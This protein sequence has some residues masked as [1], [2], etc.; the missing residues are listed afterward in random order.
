MLPK[1]HWGDMAWEDFASGDTARWIA[2]LPVA[3]IEQHG[4][5]LPVATDTLIAEA[6]LDRVAA[7]IPDDLPATLLPVQA[8]G[9]S[10]EHLAFPGTL[11][12]SP[13]TAIRAWTEIGESV[14]RAGVRKLVIVTS[15]GGNVQAI[16][17]VARELRASLG[18]LVVTTHW[19]RFGYPDGLFT[20][21]EQHHGIHAGDIETSL[22]LAHRPD[23]VQMDKAENAEPVSVAM[24]REFR[25]LHPYTPAPFGWMTQD[26]HESGA[27]GDPRP[28]SA[29]KG[30]AALD[31][32][33]RG[34]VAL[35]QEI[36]RFDLS[37]LKDGPLG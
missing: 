35:L 30:E 33:A 14:F 5:H 22:V 10:S 15:H 8:I 3:A 20:P 13:E 4:P 36:D 6:H 21:H 25:W 7:L 11:T 32:A 19:H 23:A 12:L 2:V 16:D 28:A 17:I 27:V 18:M 24:E 37:R 29:E 34:F 31:H 9:H 1:R 26:L